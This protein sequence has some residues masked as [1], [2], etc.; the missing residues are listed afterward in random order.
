MFDSVRLKREFPVVGLDWVGCVGP[1]SKPSLRLSDASL[2]W[3]GKY[4]RHG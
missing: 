2:G 1:I 3:T 4:L